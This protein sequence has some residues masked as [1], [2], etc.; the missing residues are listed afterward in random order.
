[1]K[2]R[3][4]QSINASIMKQIK[5]GDVQMK[6]KMYYSALAT[7]SAGIVLFSGLATAYLLSIVFYWIRIETADTMAWG[8]RA[9]LNESLSSF[10]WWAVLVSVALIVIAVLITRRHGRMYKHKTSSIAVVVVAVSLL[11]GL[12]F[13]L[14]GVGTPH[15]PSQGSAPGQGQAQ[16][17]RK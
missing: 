14:L 3:T 11:A 15:Y 7:A 16:Y 8:A 13:S 5:S 1:M 10:P 4:P 9:N 2:Q 6:P 17:W 12:G